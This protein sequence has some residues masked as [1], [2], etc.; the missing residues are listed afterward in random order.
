MNQPFISL[1]QRS[2]TF[3]DQKERDIMRSTE[4]QLKNIPK[5][6]DL[7]AMS[8]NGSAGLYFSPLDTT[9]NSKKYL[10]ILKDKLK[11]F[12]DIHQY[13]FF[14]HNGAPCHRSRIV[15]DF[16][17]NQKCGNFAMAWKQSRLKPY[18]KCIKN[19]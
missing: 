19:F 17:K 18:R 13:K 11:I 12:V 10:E 2:K 6:N 4:F 9:M 5:S 16:L 8:C 3:I 14:M 7:G 1:S 15:S